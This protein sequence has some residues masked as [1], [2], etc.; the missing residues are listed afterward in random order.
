MFPDLGS[1]LLWNLLLFGGEKTDDKAI[2]KKC[3][4]CEV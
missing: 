4:I 3:I 1:P 2:T